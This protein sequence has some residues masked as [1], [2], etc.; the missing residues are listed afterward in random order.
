MKY[1]YKVPKKID[2]EYIL[3]RVSQEEIFE[4]YLN[5]DVQTSKH[6]RSPLRK[7]KHPTCNF[8]Y[9]GVKLYFMDWALFDSPKD[10]F[11]IVMYMY[12]LDFWDALDKIAADFNLVEKDVDPQLNF[13][14]EASQ[15]D[16]EDKSTPTII[17]VK[18]Q[19]FTSTDAEYLSQ[20]E[21][22][23][24][25]CEYYKVFSLKQIWLNRDRIYFYSKDDPALGYYFGTKD[26]IQMWKVYFYKRDRFRFICNTNRPQGY[27][28][29]PDGGKY[30]VITKSL[31]DVMSLYEFN[32]PSVA[33]QNETQL[34]NERLINDL[35]SKFKHLFSLYDFDRTGVATANELYRQ[36]EIPRL[37]LTNGRFGS[38]D[39]GAKDFSDFVALNDNKDVK[40]LIQQIKDER[41]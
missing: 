39:Y 21:I 1:D 23:K 13:E 22:T 12:D 4:Y 19:D 32:I 26:G 20:Y 16:P 14:Y 37:F 27:P 15:N 7:D 33:P 2:K 24:E 3:S 34:P 17:E 5:V 40:E 10:C 36:Y 35:Q 38:V 31:K 28:Q 25:T 29:L 6:I 9:H 41:T 30:C 8:S 18:R 11:N